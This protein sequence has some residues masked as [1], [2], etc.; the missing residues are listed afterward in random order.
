MLVKIAVPQEMAQKVLDGVNKI[1]VTNYTLD[2]VRI[3]L[4]EEDMATEPFCGDRPVP[5]RVEIEPILPDFVTYV[6]RVMH[7]QGG[8]LEVVTESRQIAHFPPGT[9]K[10]FIWPACYNWRYDVYFPDDY[11][12]LLVEFRDGRVGLGF[13]P[14][15]FP[16]DGCQDNS[17]CMN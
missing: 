5:S 1:C 6:Q 2:D 11:C 13:D 8:R 3:S 16:F 14:R 17:G 4:V 7:E 10:R 15:E 12:I 9:I